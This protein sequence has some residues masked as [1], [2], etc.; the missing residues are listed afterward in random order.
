MKRKRKQRVDLILTADWHIREDS[1]LCREPDEFW[2][3]QERK[4]RKVRKLQKKY[5]CPVLHSGDLFHHWKPSPYLLSWCFLNLP[6]QFYTIYGQHDLPQHNYE[7][8]TK[9][10]IYALEKGGKLTTYEGGSWGRAP[11]TC[12]LSMERKAT[13]IHRFVWDGKKVP[14]PN[15]EEITSTE[16]LKECPEYDLIVTGDHHK[17]FTT[18]YDGRLLVNP[19][20]L[21]RQDASYKAHRPRV[22]LYNAEINTAEAHFLD[23]EESVISRDHLERA[24]KR[25][26]RISAFVSSLSEEWESANSF[27]SNLDRFIKEN[28]QRKPILDIIYKSIE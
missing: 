6:D 19:G 8:R 2:A 14:W 20:C 11:I 9:S 1:P 22:Y 21:T 18:K 23:V 4:V 12:F 27:E 26:T 3:S 25:E 16:L 7:L 5:K 13:M 24:K 28:K 15:C 10:G 17:P